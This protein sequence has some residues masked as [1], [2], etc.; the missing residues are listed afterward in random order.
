MISLCFYLS[1]SVPL[2]RR[3]WLIFKHLASKDDQ[4]NYH[5]P[6]AS[7]LLQ[8]CKVTFNYSP[9]ICRKSC[10]PDRQSASSCLLLLRHEHLTIVLA[11]RQVESRLVLQG[12][13]WAQKRACWIHRNPQQRW[14]P[15]NVKS[16]VWQVSPWWKEEQH[17]H[18]HI[19]FPAVLGAP[20]QSR[21]C[22]TC[23]T[24]IS[25]GSSL[26]V[27]IVLFWASLSSTSKPH[28]TK[29]GRCKCPNILFLWTLGVKTWSN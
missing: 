2:V 22:C 13:G 29:F 28:T 27:T 12:G 10:H 9:Q 25:Q 19:Y 17:R 6:I 3:L 18:G 14:M 8:P 24:L 20:P 1:D 15:G 16:L 23:T 21:W 7:L 5:H 11:R 26:V 4:F